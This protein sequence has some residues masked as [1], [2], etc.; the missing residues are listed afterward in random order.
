[1]YFMLYPVASHQWAGVLASCRRHGNKETTLILYFNVDLATY[2][3]FKLYYFKRKH[4][5]D[6]Y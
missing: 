1:M 4:F 6:E 3:K 5:K 2:T